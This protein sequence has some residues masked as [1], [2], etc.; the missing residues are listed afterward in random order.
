MGTVAHTLREKKVQAS[1]CPFD[2]VR[3][4]FHLRCLPFAP[5]VGAGKLRLDDDVRL[6]RA[7][8]G[9]FELISPATLG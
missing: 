3:G 1:Q 2:A 5:P 4:P 6:K 8:A 7:Q 9:R